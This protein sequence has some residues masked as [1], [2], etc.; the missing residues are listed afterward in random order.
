M[1]RI[2]SK[3]MKLKVVRRMSVTAMTGLR[4]GRVSRQRL[5]QLEAPSTAAAS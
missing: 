4:M 3:T 1:A 2:S 5:C